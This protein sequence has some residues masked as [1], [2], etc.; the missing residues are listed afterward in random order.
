MLRRPPS[1]TR[2]DTLFPYTTLFRSGSTVYADPRS[3]PTGSLGESGRAQPR[4]TAAIRCRNDNF[5]GLKNGSE[6]PMK[7]TDVRSTALG[8]SVAALLAGSAAVAQAQETFITIGTGGQTGVYY[9][10]GG[11]V[12]RLVNRNTAE[13]HIKCTHTTG[14]SVDNING[15]RNGDLNRSEE[16][17]SELQSLMR[18]SYAAFCLKKKNNA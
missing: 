2:T 12:C 1:S 4:S 17:T 13:H 18:I 9:Q 8:L 10:V 5:T 3:P 16:H 7:L 11:A 14:G 15:I 6:G